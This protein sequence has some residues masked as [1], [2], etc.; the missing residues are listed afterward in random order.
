MNVGAG[1]ITANYDGV[2]KHHTKIGSGTKTGS[3][4]VMV[5]PVTLGKNVTVAAGSVVTK[6]VSDNCLVIAR[7][8]Q[9]EI[10]DWQTPSKG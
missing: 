3:N 7:S 1:T 8:R 5:A 10:A 2:K 4:S 9:R 6:D